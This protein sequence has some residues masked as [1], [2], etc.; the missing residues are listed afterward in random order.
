MTD[1]DDFVHRLI[2]SLGPQP[3]NFQAIVAAQ[4]GPAAH[5]PDPSAAARAAPGRAAPA[6]GA[7]VVDVRTELQFDEAHIPGA[8]CITALR[9]GFGSKLA[10]LADPEQPVVIVGRDDEDARTAVDLALA[11]GI[12]LIAGYL[13]GGM[14]SWREEKLDVD[15]TERIDVDGLHERVVADDGVQI[16]DVREETEWRRGHIPGSVHVPYHDIDG[17]PDGDR[18]RPPGRGDLRLGSAQ[19]RWRRACSA[20]R[21]E[22]VLHVVDGGVG[23]GS[24][25]AGRPSRRRDRLLMLLAAI[26]FGV[27]IGLAVGMLGGGGSV[28]AV[29]VLVYVLGRT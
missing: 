2:D 7:L 13:A 1:E 21:T 10:W 24:A 15:R 20:L 12:R 4:P 6:D 29:P 28:L 18:P 16:L 26:P 17:I 14:T 22:E 3:P 9:A 23:A 8:V 27:A 11:V 25:A 5:P 19:R